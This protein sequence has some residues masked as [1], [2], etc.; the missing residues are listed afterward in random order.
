MAS[1]LVRLGTLINL[2]RTLS[3]IVLD[4]LDDAPPLP[5]STW[6]AES[7][8]LLPPLAAGSS[9]CC[10]G[11]CAAFAAKGPVGGGASEA[12]V[13]RGLSVGASKLSDGTIPD[14]GVPAAGVPAAEG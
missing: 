12:G 3:P 9:L 10:A 7:P 6:L 14:L 2:S 5:S 4:L 13:G 1:T 11:A 8:L